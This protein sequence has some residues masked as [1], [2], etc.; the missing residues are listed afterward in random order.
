MKL[1]CNE[2][3]KNIEKSQYNDVCCVPEGIGRWCLKLSSNLDFCTF[4]KTHEES[5]K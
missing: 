3:V 5:C 2:C 1:P 4:Y